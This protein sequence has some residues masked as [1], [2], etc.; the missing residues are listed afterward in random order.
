MPDTSPAGE[1]ALDELVEAVAVALLEGRALRLPMVGED[2]DLVRPRRVAARAL[3]VTEGVVE[4][5]QGLERVCALEA[6]VVRNLVVARERRVDGG[7]A[8]HHVGEHAR[9]DQVPHEDAERASHQRVDAA[10]VAA[11][12]HVPADRTQRR[13]P[14][15]DDLP[16][17]EDERAHRVFAVREER[18]VAGIGLLLRLHP[19]DGEDHVL[20]LAGEEVS[21]ARAAVDQ[22]ADA[23]AAAA[24]DLRAVGR[25]GARHQRCGLLLHPAEGRDVLVRAQ[26]DPRLARARLRGEIGL[27][28]GETMRRRAPSAPCSGRCRPAS[29]GAAPAAR[30]RRSPDRRSRGHRCWR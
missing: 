5:A 19:A 14:L 26:E 25:R 20:R 8:A 4:L 9:D 11:R 15:E 12:L 24:L 1:R 18:P 7:P 29:P 21:A 23:G 16:A 6:R 17:E 22:Q 28:L 13:N 3:D 2:D 30:A 10:T 27:P